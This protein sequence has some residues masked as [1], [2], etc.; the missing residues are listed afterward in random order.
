MPDPISPQPSTPTVRMA[1]PGVSWSQPSAVA[2][3]GVSLEW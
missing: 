2:R 1:M 3:G